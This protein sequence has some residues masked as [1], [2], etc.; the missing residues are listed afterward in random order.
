MSES[1]EAFLNK[2]FFWGL[3]GVISASAA[4]QWQ[5]YKEQN[6]MR[7]EMTQRFV[8]IANIYKS[9]DARIAA[10]ERELSEAKGQMVGWDTLKR[11]ELFLNAVPQQQRGNALANALRSE[12]ETSKP[13]K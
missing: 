8:E 3:C 6:A 4:L 11:I 9:H 5:T 12:I 10:L 13:K 2:F 7:Q 1:A